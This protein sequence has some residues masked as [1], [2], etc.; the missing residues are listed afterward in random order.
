MNS[1]IVLCGHES[2][3]LITGHSGQHNKYPTSAWNFF[4]Q[5]D[6]KKIGKAGFAT[7]RGGKKGAYQ[8]HVTR[9]SKVII[10]YERLNV[11]HLDLYK[12]GYVIRLFPEQ[13]FES[14]LT[15]KAEFAD[16]NSTVKVGVNAFVLYRSYSSF[17]NFPPLPEWTVRGLELNGV[18]VTQRSQ[19]VLD[20]GHY[21]LRLPTA[22]ASR[23][24]RDEG[25]PQGIFAPEYA[26]E[27]TN[28]LSKC[29]LAWLTV[30][31][32]GSPYATSQAR[33]IKAILDAENLGNMDDFES[34]GAMRR[35]L[36][37][38]PLCL[39]IL[40]YEQ[41]HSMVSFEEEA[42][43]GNASTQIEGATRSTEA[44]LY[45]LIP[46]V[47]GS[48][49]H[50]PTYVAWG[51]ATCNTRLG[52]RI[53]YSLDQLK[54]MGLKVGLITEGGLETIGWISEDYQMIRSP[55]GA[56][57]I[58]LCADMNESEEL[59]V[60]SH[61]DSDIELSDQIEAEAEAIDFS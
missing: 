58:Q 7:P 49:Q 26:D 8:N 51:H 19:D 2:C 6:K 29:A 52:Q 5:K 4:E 40:K 16:E 22:D 9:S 47:Y 31:T 12:N 24:E 37:S 46:L 20:T 15:P 3:R 38:C 57:W 48:L 28:Y 53:S 54:E 17:E 45:H 32:L 50:M 42:G 27:E 43:L 35:N 59:G 61:P 21:V 44:N 11:A 23:P 33:H 36:T 60:E 10:P 39:R 25:P 55:L 18:E 30:N 41:L 56:V 14:A 34:K 13:Y 1:E